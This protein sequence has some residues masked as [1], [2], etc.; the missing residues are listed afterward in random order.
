MGGYAEIICV[1]VVARGIF[2]IELGRSSARLW[3]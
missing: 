3:E 1:G 2:V